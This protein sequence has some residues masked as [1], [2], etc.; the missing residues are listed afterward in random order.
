MDLK[1]ELGP[2]AIGDEF[3]VLL[4]ERVWKYTLFCI[5]SVKLPVELVYIAIDGVAPLA[6]ITQQRKRRF[7]S[8]WEK[9]RVNEILVKRGHDELMPQWDSNAITPGT[10]FMTKLNSFLQK[11]IKD[12]NKKINIELCGADLAGEGEHKIMAYM[13]DHPPGSNTVDVIYGL[14]AD[15]IMLTMLHIVN[16]KSTV[17]LMR[18]PQYLKRRVGN[19]PFLYVDIPFLIGK[20]QIDLKTQGWGTELRDNIHDYI[21]LCFLM[22]NDFLPTLSFIKMGTDALDIACK[23]YGKLGKRLLK[24]KDSKRSVLDQDT[25]STLLMQLQDME[26]KRLSDL[27]DAYMAQKV[28]GPRAAVSSDEPEKAAAQEVQLYPQYNEN[29][30]EH[31]SKMRLRENGWRRRYYNYLFSDTDNNIIQKSCHQYLRGLHWCIDYYFN[32]AYDDE[33][34]YPFMYSPTI[35]DL[36]NYL[37]G[38]DAIISV[39]TL[40]LIPISYRAKTSA[41]ELKRKLAT[42]LP[43]QSMKTLCPDMLHYAN[44]VESGMIHYFPYDFRVCTYM[45]MHTWEC[46]PLIA[47]GQP[48]PPIK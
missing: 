6:K 17:Y 35:T 2:Q 15:L 41:K 20:L 43:P 13:R 26:Q 12:N 45:K 34:V 32:T 4:L 7:M 11:R 3:E 5:E 8:V 24:T 47:G 39:S 27:H 19:A 22:G 10:K 14:D 16:H 30:F 28:I 1:E 18:E 42:V 36:H 33:F 25:L 38:G 21:V 37:I 44:D 40:S 31:A 46:I 9:T 48:V 29:K 23:M